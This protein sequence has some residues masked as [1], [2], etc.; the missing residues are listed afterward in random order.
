MVQSHQQ[1]CHIHHHNRKIF[2]QLLLPPPGAAHPFLSSL[3]PPSQPS[4]QNINFITCPLLRR[5]YATPN[6]HKG[7][8]IC[9]FVFLLLFFG[10]YVSGD[11]VCDNDSFKAALCTPSVRFNAIYTTSRSQRRI[12]KSGYLRNEPGLTPASP[13]QVLFI[14]VARFDSIVPKSWL[15]GDVFKSLCSGG[16]RVAFC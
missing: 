4:N 13:T 7:N 8:E 3:F 10:W 12:K 2:L 11:L 14:A 5:L 1:R 15:D 16:R 6:T 9:D